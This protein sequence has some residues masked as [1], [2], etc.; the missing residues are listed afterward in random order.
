MVPQNWAI[1]HDKFVYHT[2]QHIFLVELYADKKAEVY[3]YKLD[4]EIQGA[5]R[6]DPKRKQF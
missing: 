1:F 6:V 4:D 3:C 2:D 5:I